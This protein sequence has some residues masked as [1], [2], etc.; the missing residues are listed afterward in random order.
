MKRETGVVSVL[1]IM[2]L[3][4][5]CGGG[6]SG[7]SS[8][9]TGLTTA[10]VITDNNAEEI[11]L[12]AFRG[13]DLGANA[14]VPLAPAVE[15]AS[16]VPASSPAALSLVRTVSRAAMTAVRPSGAAGGP[17]LRAP[18]TE[19]GIL[20]DG[21][22]GEARYTIS[23]DD[24]TGVFTGTFTFVDF[25]GDGGGI[26]VGNVSVSG[27][28]TQSSIRILFNFQTVTIQ[29]A[30]E[31]VTVT[32]VGTVDLTASLD[33]AP[34]SDTATLNLFLT[35]NVTLKTVWLSNVVVGT[36]AGTGTSDVTLSGRIY[37]HDYGYVDVATPIPFHYLEGSSLPSGG[38]MIV[39][40]RDDHGIR[41]TVDTQTQYTLDLELDGDALYDD[42][43]VILLW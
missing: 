32:A 20:P 8:P 30:T 22:G 6:G 29:D 26:V 19:S 38:R 18:F 15:G 3:L 14:V 4:S 13:G 23:G 11:A 34:G 40:G 31:G 43:T 21:F 33:A 37:L 36:T 17:S 2:V 7:A 25:H 10:A 42:L 35:D 12:A 9:Y 24:V 27:T 41:L 5:S 1:V 39:T 16:A 28:V